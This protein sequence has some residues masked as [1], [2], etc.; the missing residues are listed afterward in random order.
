MKKLLSA[1]ILL[2]VM[3]NAHAQ[4]NAIQMQQNAVR[5]MNQLQ[6]FSRWSMNQSTWWT[7]H[8]MGLCGYSNKSQNRISMAYLK[9]ISRLETDSTFLAKKK[10][11]LEQDPQKNEAKILKID[12]AINKNASTLNKSK[13]SYS[14]YNFSNIVQQKKLNLQTKSDLE[15]DLEKIK[16]SS[17]KK[18]LK[19]IEKLKENIEQINHQNDN[20]DFDYSELKK[21]I[22]IYYPEKT[23]MFDEMIQNPEKFDEKEFKK[24]ITPES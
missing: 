9:N 14:I 23:Q 19:K 13:K 8:R 17:E 18:D 16:D 11:K 12:E 15:K 5:Q 10:S 6:S 4:T 3:V 7:N 20:L 2:F 1:L 22:Q 21:D 24:M